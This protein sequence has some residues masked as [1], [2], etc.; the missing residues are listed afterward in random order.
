ML[1]RLLISILVLSSTV[2]TPGVQERKITRTAGRLTAPAKPADSR[3]S[4]PSFRGPNASG[5]ADGQNLPDTWDLKTGVNIRWRIPIPGLG[6][7]SPIVWGDRV[8]VTSAVSSRPDATF[9]PGLYGAG[10]PSDDMTPHR[11]MVYCIDTRSGKVVW[12]RVAYEGVPVEK[13]HMKSTY[14]SATPAT[15]GRIVVAWF[16]SQG[17][18][19]YNFDGTLRWK[20][21]LGHLDV[22]A[23]NAPGLEWGTASSPIIWNDLVFL[24]ADTHKDSF[25]LA[26]DA[27]TGDVRWKADR[28]ELPSWGTPTLVT[29]PAGPQL[30][31]NGS[32]FIRAYDPRTGKE[33]W[34]LGRSSQITAPTPIFADGVIVVA[35]GR[36]P[37]RPIFVVRPTASGDITL[38]EGKTSSAAIVWSRTARGPYMP[39]PIAYNGSLYVLANNGV[40]HAYKLATGEELYETRVPQLG[41]GFSASPLAADGKIYVS[42]EDGDMMVL[43]AGPEFKHLATNT[44]GEPLMATPALSRGVMYVRTSMHLVS[45]GRSPAALT[46]AE[47]A[48]RGLADAGTKNYVPWTSLTSDASAPASTLTITI[49]V[50]GQEHAAFAGTWKAEIPG[51]QEG[52]IIKLAVGGGAV[53]GDLIQA[54]T[55]VLKV[56]DATIGGNTI[57][58][59]VHLATG[60]R[61]IAF[62]GTLTGDQIEFVRTVQVHDGGVPGGRGLFGAGG[63]PSFVARRMDK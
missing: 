61:T 10:T 58:F 30:V 45:V 20:V 1:A 26:L 44:F 38:P 39:T 63:A 53:E 52:V 36:A 27:A 60:N 19:A 62:A 4:W 57:A 8:F 54:A 48:R 31:T 3:G 24:Q 15:D 16:G 34:R 49:A 28:D 17:V 56:T 40:F 2:G 59:K 23:Y 55:R 12:E 7:S 22:G 14:A 25:L 35:S 50:R 9:V 18:Y 5:V 29:T 37:E 46:D 47:R 51:V 33:L 43:A 42:G 32:K 13:R 41:S 11:W 21:D 6:H